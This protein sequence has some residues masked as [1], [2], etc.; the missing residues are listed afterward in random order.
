M[1]GCSIS[2]VQIG[3]LSGKSSMTT[4]IPVQQCQNG[5]LTSLI[6]TRK[7]ILEPRN[8]GQKAFSVKSLNTILLSKTYSKLN[9]K[10]VLPAPGTIY[11]MWI[12]KE[13]CTTIFAQ[14]SWSY[15][16]GSPHEEHS[17]VSLQFCGFCKYT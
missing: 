10:L 4:A 2:L 6:I 17:A 7:V 11:W 13:A 12:P 14:C 9:S 5:H 3:Q 16:P 8:S 15:F 1:R